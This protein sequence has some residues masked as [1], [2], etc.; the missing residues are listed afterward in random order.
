M[1]SMR[2]YG[3][4]AVLVVVAACGLLTGC[5]K[6]ETQ[7]E[8][9]ELMVLCGDSFVMPMGKLCAEFTAETGIK[10]T[11]SQG[12]SEVLFPLVK[13]GEKGD[14]FITHDPFLDFVRDANALEDHVQVG[15]VAPVLAVQKGNPK[16]IRSVDDLV[17]P[18]LTV[19]LTDPQYSSCGELV[20]ALLEKK[21]IKEEVLKNVGNRLARQHSVL[22]NYLEL[23][24]VD[25][26]IM[27]NGVAHT[28]RDDLEVVKTP[29]EYDKETRV[30]IMSLSYSKQTEALKRFIEF[31]RG[32]GE[33]VFAEFG[34]VK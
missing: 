19:G 32:R 30:H 20:Y 16:G 12:G 25:A 29:Y 6:K 14:I 26:V 34:Y 9:G 10:T 1:R 2:T 22:G 18:G 15:F 7:S 27:W 23:K 28:F 21:G 11:T 3:I 5:G 24:T 13:V 31:A 8:S 4:A 33:T 17:R